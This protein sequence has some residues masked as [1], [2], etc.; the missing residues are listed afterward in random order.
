MTR[1][2]HRLFL[3]KWIPCQAVTSVLCLLFRPKTV[4][5]ST[6][7]C[8]HFWNNFP[9]ISTLGLLKNLCSFQKSYIKLYCTVYGSVPCT[10]LVI[11]YTAPESRF[12]VHNR[13]WFQGRGGRSPHSGGGKIWNQSINQLQNTTSP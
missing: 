12:A 4:H 3:W 13:F 1:I 7:K 9:C 6:K 10:E 2:F 5:C 11:G 8:V